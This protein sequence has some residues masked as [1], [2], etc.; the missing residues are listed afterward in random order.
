MNNHRAVPG[1]R[2]VEKKGFLKRTWLP[3]FLVVLALFIAGGT[4]FLMDR[5]RYNAVL[6]NLPKAPDLSEKNATL[7]QEIGK[8]NQ[9]IGRSLNVGT[10]GSEL[11]RKIGEL[12]GLYQTNHF[13]DQAVLCYELAMEE[14][15]ENPHWP[16]LLVF[17]RQEK[18]E[19][20]SVLNLLEKT[21]SLAPDYSPA[22]LRMADIHFKNGDMDQAKVFY[23]RRLKLQQ[24]DPHALLGLARIALKHSQWKTARTRLQEAVRLNPEFGNAHRL[25]ASVYE[26]DGDEEKMRY[27]LD[28]AS[29]CARFRPA[30]DPWIEDLNARCYDV[31]QLLVLGSKAITAL[32]IEEASSFFGRAKALEPGNP[33]VHLALGRLCFMVGQRVEARGFFEEAIRLDPKSD[34]AYFQLGL[35]LRGEGRLTKAKQMFLKALGFHP[36]NPNVHNNLG[37]ILLEQQKFKKAA[38]TFHKALEIYP[39]HINARYNLG[40]ALWGLGNTAAAMDEYRQVLG[41]KPHWAIPANS[42]AWILAT[43]RNKKLR[44][45][46]EA[47]QWA[48]IACKNDGRKN[49]EYLDTLAAAYAEAGRFEE[50]V[51]TARKSLN[52][53][54]S[55]GDADLV[56]EVEK[57]LLLYKAE[58]AFTE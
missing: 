21:L 40:L 42:L 15:P 28:R 8:A 18:G 39:E 32:D 5:A 45:G 24:G 56:E 46:I 57:R 25:L 10:R 2:R 29:K 20:E 16:Y 27:S 50:A 41:V 52:L 30:A 23:E 38:E 33:K 12:G 19:S 26:H 6:D 58:K 7:T 14:E 22:V 4:W 48:L 44:N 37:V 31:D 3:S 49:P 36:N 34:E 43:D 9:E 53:A 55:A 17:V 47:V 13:Y 54:R 1:E 51:R 35:I 11:G